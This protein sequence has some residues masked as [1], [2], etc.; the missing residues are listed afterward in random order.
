MICGV[1]KARPGPKI[2]PIDICKYLLLRRRWRSRL[3]RRRAR[4]GV[5]GLGGRG[6]FFLGAG[7]LGSLSSTTIFL[8]GGGGAACK[9]LICVR[10]WVSSD[11][12]EALSV[13]NRSPSDRRF[14]SRAFKSFERDWNSSLT[15]TRRLI[16]RYCRAHRKAR[17]DSGRA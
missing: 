6:T 15:R 14:R 5:V 16:R 8:G 17:R 2:E 9:A 4:L 13:S 11:S 7:F 10:N 1:Q 12:F 3:P